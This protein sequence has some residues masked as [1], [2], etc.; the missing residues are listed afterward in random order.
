MDFIQG[1]RSG[2]TQRRNGSRERWRLLAILAPLREVELYLAHACTWLVGSTPSRR[3]SIRVISTEQN[4]VELHTIFSHP[5]RNGIDPAGQ[6]DGGIAAMQSHAGPTPAGV[7][8]G[9]IGCIERIRVVPADVQ[10]IVFVP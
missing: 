6:G 7:E 10:G 5:H 2:R 1:R 4:A 9:N 8:P 3:R